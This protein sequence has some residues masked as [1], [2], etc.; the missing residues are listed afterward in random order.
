MRSVKRAA[1]PKKRG[2]A[3]QT[4]PLRKVPVRT[5]VRAKG[6]GRSSGTRGGFLGRFL[7]AIPGLSLLR[8]PMLLLTLLLLIGGLGAGLFA[9]GYISDTIADARARTLAAFTSAGFTVDEITLEGNERT[10]AQEVYDSLG[11]ETGISIFDADPTTVRDNLLG[12]PWVSD[13]VVTR[14]FP[15]LVAIRLIEKRPF[16]MWQVGSAIVVVERSGAV[17]DGAE[18]DPS[19]HL[20]L[21]IGP[22]APEVAAPLL[23]ALGNQRALGAR[24]QGVERISERRWDLILDRGVRVRLPEDGWEDQLGELE[25]LIVERGLL[26]RDL[27]IID[28]RFPDSYIFQLHN[29]DSQPV[30]RET[31]V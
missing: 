12:L 10:S 11:I 24:L 18:P 15:D 26:E 9:G 27:E 25:R 16:A 13:V 3:R 28:L 22:G 4:A 8:R 21:L 20:P 14:H 17:I 6:T 29:G 2:G 23:D 30:S 31:P 5:A 19:A 7:G 1:T